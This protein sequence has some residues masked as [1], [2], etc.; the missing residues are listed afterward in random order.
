MYET[1]HVI[2]VLKGRKKQKKVNERFSRM[3]LRS[4]DN[5]IALINLI[6]RET[7]SP[8]FWVV[9]EMH[10]HHERRILSYLSNS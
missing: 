7:T 6:A 8:V 1:L 2:L 3:P 4:T 10:E 5:C 9:K